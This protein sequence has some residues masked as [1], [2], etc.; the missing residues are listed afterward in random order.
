[1][2]L[3]SARPAP[4]AARGDQ[5]PA[6]LVLAWPHPGGQGSRLLRV[7]RPP[8]SGRGS[9]TCAA[10]QACADLDRAPPR[11]WRRPLPPSVPSLE[12][13]PFADHPHR[14]GPAIR[15]GGSTGCTRPL[16]ENAG[17]LTKAPHPGPAERAGGDPHHGGKPSRLDLDGVEKV[18]GAIAR[19][20]YAH[21]VV[22]G[23][24][25][26][27]RL[28]YDDLSLRVVDAL[29][30]LPVRLGREDPEQ[31]QP[32]GTLVALLPDRGQLRRVGETLATQV[33]LRGGLL[34]QRPDLVG[35]QRELR[36]GASDETAHPG[37][38][39]D[40]RRGGSGSSH[41]PSRPSS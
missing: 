3:P 37:P 28:P 20:L 27:S 32:V 13:A 34:G 30:A 25:R 14:V 5:A 11:R 7:P 35:G 8:A 39:R 24:I 21:A 16:C 18:A 19:G 4:E 26:P 29:K 41:A 22:P 15:N 33:Q 2:K 17:E 23:S 40:R 10:P 36:V 6:S 9:T 12:L 1:M 38:A 31:A